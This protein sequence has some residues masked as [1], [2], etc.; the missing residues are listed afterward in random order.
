MR[1]FVL[2]LTFFLLFS[3]HHAYN[4][5]VPGKKFFSQ[6][7]EIAQKAITYGKKIGNILCSTEMQ[8]AVIGAYMVIDTIR[9]TAMTGKGENLT[10]IAPS[11]L[12][13]LL[14]DAVTEM[15]PK[16]NINFALQDDEGCYA[17]SGNLVV[18]GKYIFSYPP[19]IQKYIIGHEMAHIEKEHRKK[20]SKNTKLLLGIPVLLVIS[21]V[22][23]DYANK[24]KKNNFRGKCIAG[25]K[26]VVDFL[27][28]NPIIPFAIIVMLKSR[29]TQYYEKE[30]D[31]VSATRLNCA[32]GAINY[33][34]LC[35]E[36]R[37]EYAAKATWKSYLL[38]TKIVGSITNALGWAWHPSAEKRIEYLAP[39]A[40]QQKVLLADV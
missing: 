16:C 21:K 22:I 15:N 37:K 40:K 8:L 36:S 14:Q 1:L 10:P 39:I 32:Q 6:T 3:P 33:A 28:R 38:P 12:P 19:E 20:I 17:T 5:I 7:K 11:E 26:K 25:A 31:I 29:I 30:A 35:I 2:I 27:I 34:N 24:N 18:L 23:I 13:P 4:G 9:D